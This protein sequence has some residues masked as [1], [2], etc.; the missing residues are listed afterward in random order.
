MNNVPT[1]SFI[2]SSRQEDVNYLVRASSQDCDNLVNACVC[3]CS[4]GQLNGSHH[5]RRVVALLGSLC[6]QGRLQ[7][8]PLVSGWDGILAAP[9][10]RH[11]IPAEANA[12]PE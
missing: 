6:R 1:Y 5:F 4:T 8:G 7:R 10:R 3:V 12:A 9:P 2:Y 11:E